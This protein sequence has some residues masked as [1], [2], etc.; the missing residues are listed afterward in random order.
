MYCFDCVQ[1]GL[2]EPAVAVCV[3]CGAAA[4]GDH[5]KWVAASL[6]RVVGMGGSSS[7]D[8]RRLQCA[9]CWAARHGVA[10]A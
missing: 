9:A 5:V 3:D 2:R 4:C 1:E 6:Q 8:T 7:Y 10:A